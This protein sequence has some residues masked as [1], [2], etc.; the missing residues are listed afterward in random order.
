MK[1][2]PP[3]IKDK[4]LT[5]RQRKEISE[6]NKAIYKARSSIIEYR[7]SHNLSIR[8][9]RALGRVAD[10]ICLAEMA[11]ADVYFYE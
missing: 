4:P 6:L 3:K 9:Y 5:K 7:R 11:L 8:P 1:P 2:S 10:L